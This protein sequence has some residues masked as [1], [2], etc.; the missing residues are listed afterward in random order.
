MKTAATVDVPL[1]W[2]E[3]A[4][5]DLSVGG[6]SCGVPLACG[7][8]ADTAKLAVV[9]S[10]GTPVPAQTWPL[11]TWPDGSVKWA[12]IALGAGREPAD[13]YRVVVRDRGGA[14]DS[15]DRVTVTAL[16]DGFEVDTGACRVGVPDNGHDI[17]RSMRV[18]GAEVA[19]SGRLVSSRQDHPEPDVRGRACAVGHVTGCVVEQD[20]PLRAVLRVDGIHRDEAGDGREWLPFTVR[21]VFAAGAPTFR[22]IHSFVWD[23]DPE[24]DF[25][26]SLGLRFTVPLRAD[27]HD[28]HVRLAGADGGFLREAVRGL[29][30]L[31]RDPG[32]EVR[33]A[34]IEGRATPPPPNWAGSV[35]DLARWIPCWGDYSLRQLTANGYTI[36]KRTA[37]DRP[38]IDVAQGTRADGLAYVGDTSGGLA[39]GLT[40]FWQSHPTGLDVRDADSDAAT[41]TTWLWSPDAAPMDLR[42]YHDGL[43][44]ENYADQLDALEIT[45]EDYEPG[46]GT[47]HGI[48]RTHE[49]TVTPFAATPPVD[50]LARIAGATAVRPQLVPTPQALHAAGVMGDWDLPDRADPRRAALEDRL[51]FMLDYY[52]GQV[53]QRSWYGFWNFGDV[54]HAYDADRHTWRYDVGGYAWDNSELSPDL[55]LWTSFLRT[56]RADVFRLAERMTRHTGDVDVYHSGPWQGLGTR[57]NVQHWGCSAKQLRIST[58]AYRRCHYFLTG[59]EHT[60]DL[61]LE[62][63]DSDT[64]FLSIDPTRKVR[65]DAATYQPERHALAVGLGTD[66]SALAATWLADWEITGNERSRDRLI[67]TMSDIGA[68]PHGFFTGEALYDLDAGRFDTA[69]DRVNVSHLSAVFGLVEVCSELVSLIDSGQIEAPGFREAWLQYCRLYL[70]SPDEQRAELGVAPSGIHLEQ[71][72]SRL[73]AYASDR[74]GDDALAER[75]WEAYFKGGEFMGDAFRAVRILPPEVLSPVDETRSLYTNDA[76]QCGL[77]TIQNLALIGD[78]LGIAPKGP[79]EIVRR[80]EGT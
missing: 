69:R 46:F 75:A 60:R 20:G 27:P 63:R 66:W 53:D 40:G 73:A 79:D 16:E 33:A 12:G 62:L 28:R 15:A 11:A 23:G 45:Y 58:P 56:G 61:M 2:L 76:A 26:S 41:L 13:G 57:H 48:G 64:T 5:P 3:D 35:A 47:A 24:R 74:T 59:D 8:V 17:V 39:V 51:D 43:G 32:A 14:E 18:G 67:G 22:L 1:R 77:A 38:W 19:V 36:H 37:A 70:A 54:M 29:T 42:F 68:L 52:I 34:Q 72:H 7:A 21:L 4:R 65:Q 30:G 49:L 9:D 44:Q 31:R 80:Q 55:W 50:E 71:A 6:V 10:A 25:L 78:Q